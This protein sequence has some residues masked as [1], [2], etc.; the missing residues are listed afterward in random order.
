[1]KK[2]N[3]LSKA[4][5]K[6]VKGGGGTS[7]VMYVVCSNHDTA[8]ETHYPNVCC[9]DWHQAETF[10]RPLGFEGPYGCIENPEVS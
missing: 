1:M 8:S 5:L 3:L 9:S 2:V 7:C 10:C 4:E 6:K